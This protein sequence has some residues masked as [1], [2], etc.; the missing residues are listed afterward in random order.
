VY[1]GVAVGVLGLVL[2][3]ANGRPGA[4][5]QSGTAQSGTAEVAAIATP[6]A[7]VDEPAPGSTAGTEAAVLAGGCFW[8]VQGVFQHTKGVTEAVSGYAGG[9]AA[10]AHYGMVGS[11]LT[12][13]AESVRVTYN[14]RQ[15]TYG[16]LLR[17]F[18]SVAHDPTELD[19]QGPD[20]GSQYRSAIF[21]QNDVQRRIAESY[22]A[23]LTEAR[24]F[25]QPIA[26]RI[27]PA[28][29][30]FPAEEQHQD[31]LDSNRSQPYIALYDMPKLEDLKRVF[32][33]FYRDQPV[34]VLA[35]N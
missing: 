20:T 27:E 5:V 33:E 12:G 3:L 4:P 11:G 18:F 15:I 19:R 24:T 13:H 8:G 26:T 28:A 10:T 6:V 22:V 16:Q 31:Y 30:F 23:Q 1:L 34:L 25:S 7:V 29:E 14:P 2:A 9:N 35:K 21:P 32:P 17:I